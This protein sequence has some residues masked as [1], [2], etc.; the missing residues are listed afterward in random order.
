MV[1]RIVAAVKQA[2]QNMV[3]ARI[4]VGV[5]REDRITMNRRLRMKDGTEVDDPPFHALAGRRRRGGLGPFDPQIGLLRVD[6]A[7]GKPLALVYNFAGH[8]YGGVPDGGATA[9]FPGF[10]SRVIESAWPGAVALFVQGT[11]G[12]TT[13]VHF[14]HLEAP[15]PTEELGTRLGLSALEAA[16]GIVTNG[17]ATIRVVHEVIEFP[18]RT[19][20][21]ERIKALLAEQDKIL[22]FYTDAGPGKDGN[23][24]ALNF[25]MF[26][27]ALPE[28]GPR[29]GISLGGLVRL[30][31]GRT[32]RPEPA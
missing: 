26:L 2:S 10:A 14:K 28:P 6:T 16:Q 22:K 18:R 1:P 20:V 27:A 15:Q 9:D 7:D 25:K 30:S 12:D 24:L 19:D 32:H 3:P 31:A 13:P 4:G 17:D 23:G 8:P 29:S 5:G 21:P 11:G